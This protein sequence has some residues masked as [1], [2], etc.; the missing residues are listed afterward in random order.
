MK[1]YDPYFDLPPPQNQTDGDGAIKPKRVSNRIHG[2]VLFPV[3]IT[4]RN[5]NQTATP[6]EVPLCWIEEFKDRIER[7][8]GQNL[9]TLSRRGGLS[10][11]EIQCAAED[12]NLSTKARR[13]ITEESAAE[14]LRDRMSEWEQND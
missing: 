1:E 3:L 12:K 2:L 11:L 7:N 14:W 8:H 4:H 10:P 9:E 13:G 5:R 6:K